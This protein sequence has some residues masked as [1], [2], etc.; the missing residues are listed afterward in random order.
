LAQGGAAAKA[1]M[2]KKDTGRLKI[3]MNA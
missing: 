3:D 2:A 1:L